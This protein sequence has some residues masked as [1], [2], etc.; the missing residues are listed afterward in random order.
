MQSPFCKKADHRS[1]EACKAHHEFQLPK[2]KQSSFP[3]SKWETIAFRAFSGKWH[4]LQVQRDQIQFAACKSDLSSP[5]NGPLLFQRQQ[6][7]ALLH[8]RKGRQT[9]RE[10]MGW[11]QKES[12][13]TCTLCEQKPSCPNLSCDSLLSS[14]E[15]ICFWLVSVS[16]PL[17]LLRASGI[18]LWHIEHCRIYRRSLRRAQSTC[19]LQV[20]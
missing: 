3:R 9:W 13:V 19:K 4:S 5:I 12:L 17:L 20:A 2:D 16:L 6:E 11:L 18:Y 14:Y 7:S 1:G 10:C 15:Q 8:T